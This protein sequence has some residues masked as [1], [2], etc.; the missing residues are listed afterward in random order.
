[1]TRD[2]TSPDPIVVT[3]FAD[4]V[5][6]EL[7]TLALQEV[8]VIADDTLRAHQDSDTQLL[9]AFCGTNTNL[10]ALSPEDFNQRKRSDGFNN[11]PIGDFCAGTVN[12]S[13]VQRRGSLDAPSIYVANQ[14]SFLLCIPLRYKQERVLLQEK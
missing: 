4:I 12:V 5:D 8:M 3:S 10:L 13:F 14:L 7:D 1:M 11:I 6:L 2:E 9:L